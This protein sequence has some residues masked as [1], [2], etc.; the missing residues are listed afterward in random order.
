M[1]LA[2]TLSIICAACAV[3]NMIFTASIALKVNGKLA[4][5]IER[6]VGIH[7]VEERH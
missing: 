7:F 1:N 5:Q 2:T 4:G 6:L 3:V